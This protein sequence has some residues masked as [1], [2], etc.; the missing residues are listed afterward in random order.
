[1][2][3]QLANVPVCDFGGVWLDAEYVIELGPAFG[4]ET[5]NLRRFS[6]DYDAHSCD[7]S[8]MIEVFDLFIGVHANNGSTGKQNAVL[9]YIPETAGRHHDADTVGRS[10]T[11]TQQ[12]GCYTPCTAFQ[13]RP[14]AAFPFAILRASHPAGGSFGCRAYA[15]VQKLLHRGCGTTIRAQ[16]DRMLHVVL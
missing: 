8:D 4:A 11:E 6:G 14:V 5:E 15:L 3:D 16:W 12:S 13:L 1:V 10:E 2:L 7:G 9:D